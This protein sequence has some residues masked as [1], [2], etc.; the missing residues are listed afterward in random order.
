MDTILY[1]SAGYS[2]PFVEYDLYI[3]CLKRKSF[4]HGWYW[5]SSGNNFVFSRECR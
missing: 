5:G 1:I 4:I 3:A 2:F